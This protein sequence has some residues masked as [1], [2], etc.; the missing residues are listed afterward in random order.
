[1]KLFST[2]LNVA[3]LPFSMAR[4][5]LDIH[6]FAEGNKSFTRQQV[7]KIDEDLEK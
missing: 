7:G 6:N 2:L 3:I 5:V 1:M 4:D